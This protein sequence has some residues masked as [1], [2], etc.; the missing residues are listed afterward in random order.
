[1]TVATP[2]A[3]ALAYI[4]GCLPADQRREF[5]QS[6]AA[7]KNLA[8]RLE[9]WRL[10]NEA[11]RRTFGGKALSQE[12]SH[13]EPAPTHAPATPPPLGR[14]L[15]RRRES[16]GRDLRAQVVAQRGRSRVASR[17]RVARRLARA[18]AATLAGV[19]VLAWSAA[20]APRDPSQRLAAAFSAYRTYAG[21]AQ[22]EFASADAA[23]LERW[24]RPRLGGWVAV[25]DLGAGGFAPVAARVVS[26]A[27]GP[28]GF[29]L[30][31][32]SADARL[33]VTIESAEASPP[34]NGRTSGVLIAAPFV[35]PAPEQATLVAP[36]GAVDLARLAE[37]V[38]FPAARER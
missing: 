24:L 23:M 13:A 18:A 38:R 35:A 29:V 4:D 9:Q 32:N 33:G 1:M 17:P 25:P 28:A 3:Q 37:M 31:R 6:L 14:D 30:Y 15:P 12:Q 26:G 7:D 34:D 20:P 5:E 22:M 10:Q 2:I 21:S 36:A 27:Q 16:L 8:A 19:I 11:I